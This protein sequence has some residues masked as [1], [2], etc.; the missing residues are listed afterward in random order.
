M[1]MAFAGP[2][3][4]WSEVAARP[5]QSELTAPAAEQIAVTSA[6]D[7]EAGTAAS[8]RHVAVD[9]SGTKAVIATKAATVGAVLAELGVTPG[10]ADEVAPAAETP[11]FDGMHIA[12]RA[13]VPATLI[14]DGARRQVH[15]TSATVGEFLVEQ[16]IALAAHDRVYPAFDAPLPVNG[17]IHV[18]RVRV[19]TMRVATSI[20]APV[21]RRHS[22]RLEAGHTRIARRGQSGQRIL[23]MLLSSVDGHRGKA[24]ILTA[25]LA[26]RPQAEIVEIGTHRNVVQFANFAAEA[27]SRTAFMAHSAFSMIATAYTAFCDGCSGT[28]RGATGIR[29]THG[30]VAVDPRIIPLGSHLYIPGYGRA[31]AGDTGGAIIGHRVDLAMDSLSEA[32]NFGSRAVTVYVLDT[33]R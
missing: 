18:Q 6:R 5:A 22:D 32:L 19:W 3:L 33:G 24:R 12:Y 17:L 4:I 28:G 25:R 8:Q 23:T 14:V 16:H 1:V 2:A 31:I 20:P 7:T 15:S 11:V 27:L 9:I 21:I 13:S 26:R 29:V 30:V 10:T